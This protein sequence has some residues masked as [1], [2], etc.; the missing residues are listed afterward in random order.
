[1]WRRALVVTGLVWVAMTDAGAAAWTPTALG[2]PVA[3]AAQYPA[4]SARVDRVWHAIPGLAGWTW[5][6]TTSSGQTQS[7]WRRVAPA[8]SLSDLPPEPI[9]R[10][11]D[12]ERSVCLMFNV[13]WG[14]EYV[15][16]L[17]TTLARAGVP[18]TF[19]LDGAWVRRHPDLARRIVHDGHA[20]GSHGSGHPDFRKLNQTALTRQITGTRDEIAHTVGKTSR[21]LAPPAGSYDDRTVKLAR[22]Q[23]I[24]TIL[25]SVD[26]VDWR[27][28]PA[29]VI[30]Q[31]TLHGAHPGA[32]VLMHP[33]QPTAQALPIIIA[34]LRRDGYV[35]K[36][37][38]QVVREERAV[39][40]TSRGVE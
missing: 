26:T 40:P 5:G 22:Q 19:F 15:P 36:T 7:M 35:F 14:E 38:E 12:A 37:V 10:G 1:M 8:R 24:Y 18:A 9:Y 27:R 17:L 29:S 20:I 31:R 11:P 33:T 25:W 32:L 16:G 30:V 6:D 39:V 23:G 13:S 34:A 28:P 4:V 2:A 3:G 21:L